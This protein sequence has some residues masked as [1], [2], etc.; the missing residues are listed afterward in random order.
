MFSNVFL[1]EVKEGGGVG[2]IEQYE[3]QGK[4]MEHTFTLMYFYL[5][6][7]DPK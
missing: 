3:D 1:K 7:G 5:L 6:K 2:V 4:A